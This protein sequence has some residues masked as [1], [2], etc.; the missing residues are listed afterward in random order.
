MTYVLD[1]SSFIV[2]GHYFPERFPSFWQLF[3]TLVQ[4]G[5]IISVREVKRELEHQATRAHL[6][7][8]IKR[9]PGCFKTPDSD[10]TRFVAEIFKVPHFQQLV[11]SRQRLQGTPAADPF[12][13]AAAKIRGGSVITEE[14]SKPH[15]AKIPNVCAHFGVGC[16]NLEELMAKESWSF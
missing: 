11:G 13:I 9:N 8:W 10:E 14:A 5:R 2:L 1:T 3:D 15:A 12:L 7:D 16:L 4:S 6:V